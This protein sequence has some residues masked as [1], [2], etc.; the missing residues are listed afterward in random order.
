MHLF[1][2][3]LVIGKVAYQFF[4]HKVICTAALKFFVSVKREEKQVDA[5]EIKQSNGEWHLV[6]PVRPYILSQEKTLINIVRRYTA[7]SPSGRK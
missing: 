2:E 3:T 6:Q 5:F 7:Q 1:I 4:F